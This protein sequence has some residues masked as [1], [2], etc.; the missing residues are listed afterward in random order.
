[1]DRMS[2]ILNAQLRGMIAVQERANEIAREVGRPL[3]CNET[4]SLIADPDDTRY[5]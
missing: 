4:L 1:M 3:T 5:E 2:D